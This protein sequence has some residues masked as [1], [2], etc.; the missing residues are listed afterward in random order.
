[1]EDH[2]NKQS[3]QAIAD[4]TA[5]LIHDIN[6]P[7][8]A[9]QM[10]AK[11]LEKSMLALFDAHQTLSPPLQNSQALSHSAQQ[12]K[13]FAE[14]A[15]EALQGYWQQIEQ[16][17]AE[18]NAPQAPL[19]TVQPP[20]A[21]PG[22]QQSLRIL[23]AED[24]SIHQKI[25]RE[26]LSDSYHIAIVNNGQQALEACQAEHYD[27]ILMDFQMPALNGPEAVQKIRQALAQP[28]LIIG[29]SSQ[30]LGLQKQQL[31]QQGFS[32]FLEKPLELQALKTLL[33]DLRLL[34]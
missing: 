13:R 10:Q 5:Q 18:T 33:D 15:S 21:L 7:L 4:I 24:D 11:L 6:T 27:V 2:D 23:I 31:L 3:A 32:G 29:L 28:P 9:I 12:I 8:S 1:M 19:A 20:M 26:T 25:A 22:K 34:G 16:A 30:P 14:Q 17:L